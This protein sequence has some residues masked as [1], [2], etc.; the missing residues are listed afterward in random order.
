MITL[1]ISRNRKLSH[2]LDRMQRQIDLL[3]SQIASWDTVGNLEHVHEGL[4]H[5]PRRHHQGDHSETS[6]QSSGR[7]ARPYSAHDVDGRSLSAG[8]ER[9]HRVSSGGKS[10]VPEKTRPSGAASGGRVHQ[11]PSSSHNKSDSVSNSSTTSNSHSL[12]RRDRNGHVSATA[13]GSD[14]RSH[15]HGHGHRH[16]SDSTISRPVSPLE[17]DSKAIFGGV[18]I[19]GE[20]ERGGGGEGGGSGR[21]DELQRNLSPI[22]LEP[23]V[24][25]SEFDQ[26][27][28]EKLKLQQEFDDYKEKI[29]AD[30][31]HLL[32]VINVD[33]VNRIVQGIERIM[34]TATGNGT[35]VISSVPPEEVRVPVQ[36]TAKK[37]VPKRKFSDSIHSSIEMDNET[38]TAQNSAIPDSLQ[39][40][41]TVMTDTF[42]ED[43]QLNDETS[44]SLLDDDNK[45]YVSGSNYGIAQ[46]S[47][48][49]K[50]IKSKQNPPPFSSIFPLVINQSNS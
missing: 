8:R 26:V 39:S 13:K 29:K 9:N 36:K 46:S 7:S 12:T 14:D 21:G 1:S 20:V 35:Y 48:S 44:V 31:T 49:P 50:T 34:I 30:V 6:S 11:G 2:I 22:F 37:E 33:F 41:M 32:E 4:H 15:G 45:S 17:F 38:A 10:R 24:K 3:T 25:S 43:E 23:M 40:P 16:E 19:G 47:T 5:L 18:G 42:L 28:R 27:L